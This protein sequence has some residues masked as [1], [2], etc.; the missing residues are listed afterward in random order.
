MQQ[1]DNTADPAEAAEYQIALAKWHLDRYDRLRASTASRASVVLSAGALLSAGNAVVLSQ[2]RGTAGH[3][4]GAGL[5][6]TFSI[7]LAVSACLVIVSL[8]HAAGVLVTPKDS[9]TMLASHGQL[10]AAP[11]FNGTYTVEH[12][13]T[14]DEFVAVCRA[15]MSAQ[16]LEA[17]HV[18]LWIVIQQHRYRYLKLRKAA[19]VL[20]WA[21][22]VFLVVFLGLLADNLVAQP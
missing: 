20:R 5:L 3:G 7:G 12:C 6:T 22:V 1:A 19:R 9:R 18:E 13:G 17:A 8:F 4:A 10:P 16:I 14:F 2:L 11:L 15:Q 21:A